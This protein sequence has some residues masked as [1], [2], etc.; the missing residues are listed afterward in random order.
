[1]VRF[2][3]V[4]VFLVV[5]AFRWLT[6][7]EFPNDHFDHVALA[8]QLRLGAW[9]VRDFTDEGLP[10]FYAVSAAAWSLLKA[11]F[12]SEAIVM[13]LGFAIAAAFT[14]AAATRL[15]RSALAASVAVLAQVLLYPRPYSYP[16]LLVQAVWVLVACRAIE[17]LTARR[18]AALAA[19]T[20]LGY[21][22][23]HDHAV[24]L[25]IA[26][27][28]LLAVARWQ[29][30]LRA[31]ARALAQYAAVVMALILPHLIYVQWAAG[32]PTYL[33]I[34]RHYVSAEAAGAAYRLPLP[35]IDTEAGLWLRREAPAVNIRWVPAVDDASRTRLEQRYR[36]E[37]VEHAEGTTWRYRLRDAGERNVSALQGDP[38]VEDTHGFDRIGTRNSVIG[39]E[40]GPGWRARENSVAVLY[41][42]SWLL[43]ASA[44][45]VL[46]LRRGQLTTPDTAAAAMLI[47]L[48]FA[49]NLGFLRGPLE[50][51]LPDVAVPQTI[52]GAWLGATMWRWPSSGRGR[53][54]R[55]GLVLIVAGKALIAAAVLSQAGLLVKTTGLTDGIGGVARRWRDVEV[56]LRDATPGP[57]PSNPSAV[58]LPFFE[59]VRACTD[60]SDRLLYAWYSPEVYIV[61]DRGFA[62]DHRKFLP[63]FHSS[64]WEQERT[65]ERLRR[66]HVPFVLIPKARRQSFEASHPAV[67]QYL[68][69]RYVLMASIPDGDPGGTD[70]L[71]ES[72]W[73]SDRLYANTAWPCAGA[74]ATG[75][76]P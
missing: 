12:L 47:A 44:L 36:L 9:P 61:A 37:A 39:L 45:L 29:M 24:Y 40:V 2:G 19:A 48:A 34:S 72:S 15:S 73:T 4:A 70:I 6:L 43:P 20:A 38:N 52:L 46:Y 50:M 66:E 55:R 62:G 75:D 27:V 68:R 74:P 14:F 13:S 69:S 28:A 51:R 3:A 42:F 17:R 21:Y 7:S 65:I 57:V 54:L 76:Q 32:L 59:Y 22:F 1:M 41:W 63:G 23:R 35:S 26:T 58:L 5:L 71:R 60:R 30:G 31:V 53:L 16:K 8:Q 11:P 67:W 64:A 56:L 33:A 49:A 10:L 18:I 25:G